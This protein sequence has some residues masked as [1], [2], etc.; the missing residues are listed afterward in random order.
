MGES[1]I[2]LL[3]FLLMTVMLERKNRI[4]GAAGRDSAGVVPAERK[5]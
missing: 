2:L 1:G 3:I 4:I 5:P